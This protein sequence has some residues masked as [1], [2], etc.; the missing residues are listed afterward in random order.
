MRILS[1]CL[2]NTFRQFKFQIREHHVIL[3]SIRRRIY[4]QLSALV[5]AARYPD[6]EPGQV[7]HGRILAGR[8]EPAGLGPLS[9]AG[10]EV[11]NV[12]PRNRSRLTL[13]L[14][15]AVINLNSK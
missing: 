15:L 11:G 7:V 4:Q 2:K 1:S 12:S 10:P 8:D 14:R 3:T 13:H 9:L 6:A 5:D